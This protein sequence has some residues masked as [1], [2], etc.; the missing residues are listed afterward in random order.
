MEKIE[1]GYHPIGVSA[2]YTHHKFILYTQADGTTFQIHGGGTQ[3]YGISPLD[4]LVS[5]GI[6]TFEGFGSLGMR[7]FETTSRTQISSDV[8]RETVF[9][10]EDLKVVFYKMVGMAQGIAEENTTYNAATNNSNTLVDRIVQWSGGEAPK[11]DGEL[12]SPG[13]VSDDEYNP[14]FYSK[15]PPPLW[16]DEL[17]SKHSDITHA[18]FRGYCFLPG[19]PI[20]MWDGSQKPIEDICIGD[21][22]VSYDK[23]GNWFPV[24]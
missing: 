20:D 15:L 13:S 10:G 18:L 7:V 19:T 9:E 11:L 14:D 12:M 17:Y 1:I 3:G 4:E 6:P 8:Q 5:S 22:V 23:K 2:N 21:Q 16:G 24:M